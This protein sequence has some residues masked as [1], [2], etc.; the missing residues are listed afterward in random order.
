[1]S[2]VLSVASIVIINGVIMNIVIASFVRNGF[3]VFFQQSYEKIL[4]YEYL[5]I[6][7]STK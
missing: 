7:D 1:M 6:P 5:A 3:D 4:I 2:P